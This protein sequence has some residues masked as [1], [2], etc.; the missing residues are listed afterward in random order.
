MDDEADWK[1]STETHLAALQFMVV[2]LFQQQYFAAGVDDAWIAEQHQK[3]RALFAKHSVGGADPAIADRASAYVEEHISS[4][5][6]DIEGI[7][8]RHRSIVPEIP[9]FPLPRN[10]EDLAYRIFPQEM[11]EDERVLFHGTSSEN[12][13]SIIRE[14]FK[15]AKTLG[16]EGGLSSVS[17]APNSSGALAHWCTVRGLG[18]DGV[19]IAV[20]YED[21]AHLTGDTAARYDYKLSPQPKIIGSCR[22]PHTYAFT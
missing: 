9:E 10:L 11:E 8:A 21:V 22:V 14:G 6:S 18:V 12:Y 1:L 3:V 4:I 13:E 16:K 7:V 5:L 2:T 19:V 17:F 15:S 20:R